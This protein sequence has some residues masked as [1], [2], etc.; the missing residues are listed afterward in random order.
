MVFAV[1]VSILEG[2]FNRD[3]LV[4]LADYTVWRNTLGA[5]VTSGTH[6]DASGNG[7][8]DAAD[9]TIWKSNF[10]LANTQPVSLP[11]AT[12]QVP[13]PGSWLQVVAL[14][15]AWLVSSRLA[16]CPAFRRE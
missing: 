13:E 7:M 4:D 10:G 14:S 9:Y 3:G 8:V 5:A 1:T 15:A 12:L 6:A 11:A 16:V 2:D